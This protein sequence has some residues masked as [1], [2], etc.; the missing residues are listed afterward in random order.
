MFY[1]S[2]CRNIA[3]FS[4][5]S[6]L[7]LLGCVCLTACKLEFPINSYNIEWPSN[8]S[9]SETE[10]IILSSVWYALLIGMLATLP[11]YLKKCFENTRF[12][13]NYKL[14]WYGGAVVFQAL[15]TMLSG[16]TTSLFVFHESMALM[17]YEV[18][19]VIILAITLLPAYYQHKYKSS[20][21]NDQQDKA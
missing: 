9:F 17:Y 18:F 5:K 15:L 16:I 10:R 1:A 19:S 20:P 11:L 6:V 21:P 3:L 4:I 2:H 14:F 7:L 8:Y 13:E 12:Y